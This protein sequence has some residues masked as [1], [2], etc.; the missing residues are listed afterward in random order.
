MSSHTRRPRSGNIDMQKLKAAEEQ[1]QQHSGDDLLEQEAQGL[2]S[3]ATA[4]TPV[5]P[6]RSPAALIIDSSGAG[7]GSSS[8]SRL[9]NTRSRTITEHAEQ[10][11]QN[12]HHRRVVSRSLPAAQQWRDAQ[13]W[14]CEKQ[15]QPGRHADRRWDQQDTSADVVLRPRGSSSSSS[16]SSSSRGG[17][18]GGGGGQAEAVKETVP[19]KRQRQLSWSTRH[20]ESSSSGPIDIPPSPGQQQKPRKHASF[21]GGHHDD[22]DTCIFE[23]G[24]GGALAGVGKAA[25]HAG[26]W[27][28]CWPSTK[29]TD[30]DACG[31][32]GVPPHI[33]IW[34]E[35]VLRRNSM[36]HE[37]ERERRAVSA[38]DGE[39][40]GARGLLGSR[41]VSEGLTE[42]GSVDGH[43]PDED[44]NT[45]EEQEGEDDDDD[46]DD[47]DAISL[48]HR[49]ERRMSS[50]YVFEMDL[51][52]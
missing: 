17:G 14:E 38:L 10:Q 1:R 51:D 42:D 30:D 49:R 50:E 52:M 43:V 31:E 11:Q 26:A 19:S 32:G 36:Q 20:R 41:R 25:T 48:E 45:E 15:Q 2:P 5:S 23:G 44:G 7:A 37:E 4:T 34:E 27:Y 22:D 47:D 3:P 12:Y 40:G 8:G 39:G 28:P 35:S 46:D 24:G 6:Q 33:L 29:P 18:G 21:G 16:G 13:H 9:G